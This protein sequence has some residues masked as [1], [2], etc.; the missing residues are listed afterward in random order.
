M[1]DA[2]WKV[3][4]TRPAVVITLDLGND[5]ETGT[6]RTLDPT[7]EITQ[8]MRPPGGPAILRTLTILDAPTNQVRYKPV[9]GDL[10]VPGDYE[11]EFDITDTS[12]DIETVPDD[13]ANNYHYAIGAK[14]ALT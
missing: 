3:G 12:G 9:A 6:P 7:D 10:D 11:V 1:A 14:I 2:N 4:N 13:P 5:P 8:I